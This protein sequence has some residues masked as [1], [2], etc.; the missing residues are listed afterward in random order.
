[1]ERRLLSADKLD[2]LSH[3]ENPAWALLK[4]LDWTYVPRE[5][6]A[7]ER[8]DEREVLLRG[9]S[10]PRALEAQLGSGGREDSSLPRVVTDKP[11]T[12]H[13]RCPAVCANS[14]AARAASE[15]SR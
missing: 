2:E 10:G 13:L 6:L 4:K 11:T 1:M 5:I 7:V 14:L 15:R 8:D 12:R 3:A 9:S